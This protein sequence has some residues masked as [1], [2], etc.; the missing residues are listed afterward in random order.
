[1]IMRALNLVLSMFIFSFSLFSAGHLYA[2]ERPLIQEFGQLTSDCEKKDMN[3]WLQRFDK[4]GE[5]L[6]ETSRTLSPASF[7]RLYLGGMNRDKETD[8]FL[9][10]LFG[11]PYIPHEFATRRLAISCWIYSKDFVGALKKTNYQ[12]TDAAMSAWQ[13]CLWDAERKPNPVAD[14]FEGCYRAIRKNTAE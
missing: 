11:A 9:Y 3:V 5:R 10:F 2:A 6:Y 4:F 1:M 13:A 8:F 7:K 12:K 14:T